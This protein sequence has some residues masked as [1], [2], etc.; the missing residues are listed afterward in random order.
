MQYLLP[1]SAHIFV[2][3]LVEGQ[4]LTKKSSFSTKYESAQICQKNL[5]LTYLSLS[6]PIHYINFL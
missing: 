6:S 4:F 3:K 1:Q 5:I 2:V